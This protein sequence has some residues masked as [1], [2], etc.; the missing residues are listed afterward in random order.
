MQK[1]CKVALPPQIKKDI[2]SLKKM[3]KMDFIKHVHHERVVHLDESDHKRLYAEIMNHRPKKNRRAIAE[4]SDDD[5]DPHDELEDKQPEE[6]IYQLSQL[7]KWWMSRLSR[8]LTKQ[9]LNLSLQNSQIE[10]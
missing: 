6:G 3:K 1:L 4:S 10:G 2:K 8:R 5:E 9:H 7:N